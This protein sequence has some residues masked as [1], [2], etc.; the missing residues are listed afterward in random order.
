VA[1]SE[2]RDRLEEDVKRIS[3]VAEA[4]VRLI[5]NKLLGLYDGGDLEKGIKEPSIEEIIE[6]LTFR[7]QK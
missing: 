4:K 7:L 3:R 5:R 1:Y 2:E 6:H